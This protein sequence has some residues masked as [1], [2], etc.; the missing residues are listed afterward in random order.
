MVG[1]K[2]INING[3]HLS[4]LRYADDI[5]IIAN[6]LHELEIMLNKLN[7]KSKKVG[8][9]MNTNKTKVMYM[10]EDKVQKTNK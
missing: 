9:K 4:H 6:G 7:I 3:Q 2:G 5:I 10:G 1:S 8:L